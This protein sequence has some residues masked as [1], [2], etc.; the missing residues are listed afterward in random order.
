MKGT[1]EHFNFVH[2]SHDYKWV[3]DLIDTFPKVE[4][5]NF[6]QKLMVEMLELIISMQGGTNQIR[7]CYRDFRPLNNLFFFVA[8]P[9]DVSPLSL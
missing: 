4:L 9:S 5:F 6:T 3:R 1:L 8:M 2:G 7:I